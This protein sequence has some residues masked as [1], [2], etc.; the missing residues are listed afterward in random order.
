MDKKYTQLKQGWGLLAV[1]LGLLFS[2][3]TVQAQSGPYGNEWIVPSQQYYKIPVTRDGIHRLDYQYLTQAGLGNV[4]PSR[5]QLWR[6]GREVAVYQGGARTVFDASTYLE[7]Y[8]QRNDGQLDRDLYKSNNHQPHQLYSYYTDTAAY[9]LTY[10]GAGA[11]AARRMAE[12]L[13]AGG[14]PHAWRL[15][16]SLKVEVNSYADAP[17]GQSPNNV[18]FLPWVELGEGFYSQRLGGIADT[19]TDSLLRA[20]VPTGPGPAPRLEIRIVGSTDA[21]HNIELLVLNPTTNTYRSLARLVFNSYNFAGGRYALQRAEIGPNGLVAV[22]LSGSAG[23]GTS[24]S[25][26]YFRRAFMRVVAPQASRWI[27]P[28]RHVFFANDSLLGGP[29][30]FE[31]D[32]IPASVVGYD[33]HDP[34]NVQR[35]APAAAQTLGP[36]ARRFVF[37]SAGAARSRRLLLADAGRPFVPVRARLVRFRVINPATVNFAIITHRQMCGPGLDGTTPVA[38]AAL[39]YAKYRAS[40]AGGR[41]DTL[42]I[43]TAQLYD[44]FHY[45]EKSWLAMRHLGLWLAAAA[46]ANPNRYLLL[47]GKGIV[48]SEKGAYYRNNSEVTP[49]YGIGGGDFVLASSR[50]VSDNLIT[51]DYQHNDYVPK[52]HTGRLTTTTPQQVLNYLGKLRTHEALGAEPW[53]KNVLHLVGGKTVDEAIEFKGYLDEAKRRVERPYFG[54]KVTTEVRTSAL[55]VSVDISAQ[56]NAGLALIDF[57]GHASPTSYSLDFGRPSSALNYTN[58]GRYPYLFLNGCSAN[59]SFTRDFTIVED[60]LFTS[61]RGALGSLAESG[62]SYSGPLGVAHDTLYKLLFNDPNWYGKPITAVH[63]ELVRRLQRTS[64]FDNDTGV[65][66]LLTCG[67]QGDPTLALFAP[68]RPD[69]IASNATLSIAP[70][71]ASPVV[72]ASSDFVLNVGVANPGKITYEPVEIQ[73]TRVFPA[74]SGRPNLVYPLITRRQAWRPDTTYALTLPNTVGVGGT[75]TFLVALD[76]NNRV[77]E[78]S[79]TNNTATIDFSFLQGGLSVVSPTEF[80]ISPATQPRL[81][82]QSN[83]PLGGQRAYDFEVDTVTTF[84][85]G[86]VQ[87]TTV[88]AGVVAEWTP[89]LLATIG[90]RDSLVWYWRARFKTPAPGEDGSWATSSFRV[91][92]GSA[93]GWS[94]SHYAQFKRDTRTGV[95][96]SA[97]AGRWAFT[98]ARVPLVLRTRGGGVPRSAPSFQALL[99]AGIYLQSAAGQPSVFGCGV[100]SPNL[101]VAVYSPTSLRPVAM[102]ATFQR[103][104]QAPD[105]FYFFSKSDPVNQNSADTLDNLNYSAT[106]QQQ[107]NDFLTAVPVGSYV[108][109]VSTNRLRYTLLPVALKAR[110]QALLG[111]QLIARLADGEPLALVGQKLTATTGRLVREAGPDRSLPLPAYGQTVELRDSLRRPG[112][113]GRI[114]STRIGPAKEWTNLYSTIRNLAPSGRHTLSVVAI[115]TLGRETV[116]L[117]N[118][119]AASQPLAAAI[120]A[121]RYPY[122]RLE[123]ALADTVTRV[124]PQLQQ[125]LVTSRGLPEGVVRRDLVAATEYAPTTLAQQATG[126][127]YLSFPVKFANVS[128]ETFASPLKTRIR[129]RDISQASRPVVVD[130]LI[131]SLAPLPGAIQVIPVR[132]GVKGKFGTFV[133]EVVVNPRLQPEQNYANNELTLE[134]FTVLDNNVP[135]VL[136]VAFDGRHILNGELVSAR[137]VINIQ[138]NDEDKLRPITDRTVFTVTLL[139]PGRTSP[140]LVDLA[141]ANEVQFSVNTT[142]GSVAKLTYEPGKSTPLPDGMYTLEVQG[143]DPSNASAGSQNFQVKFEV[144]NSSQISNVYPYPNPVINKTRFVFTLTGQELPRNMKIQILSLTGRVVREI[145]MS[146]LGPLHIGNNITEFAWDGTD[147]YGDRLANGTYLY[148]VSLDDP[149]SNFGHR[150]TSGDKAFKNDWGKLV[151][152]R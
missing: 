139:R 94:Q 114:V 108:A 2:L 6:R 30:T 54:G 37:P 117:P 83:D 21:P 125:W 133:T 47:L 29:A 65:E 149:N 68:P 121:T 58:V 26:D 145:F 42:L 69:F 84:T 64:Y 57:F 61:Q 51:T 132:F 85:S 27:G 134:A 106:R 141:N 104:G 55:P 8:G 119:T 136:D 82:V 9:F 138:L 45:G 72:A 15:A 59:A 93:S 128:N 23:G 3:P 70:T 7:F 36:L 142:N 112:T 96:V 103:C 116:V 38:N 63:D 19:Q 150:A 89:T 44:Q 32:S 109:V 120:S 88:T 48:P 115:D 4:D 79:E 75:S 71:G 135:P 111:S 35:I 151:L 87:R 126:V 110:L 107:L 122:I 73:V 50:A 67:W 66:Q 113:N 60:W 24:S 62:Y 95:D 102:P 43:T 22:R 56:L 76:P 13:V 33:V 31:V 49:A 20:V 140:V 5:L 137:P 90:Q 146:E 40:T 92:P 1:L 99:G 41:Y 39:E 148:R 118:I 129:L 130:T 74:G 101:L 131:T 46:P 91:I 124:P 17:L 14:V 53:R 97:P 105:Y 12:P 80:A 144:V 77:A 28:R 100:Q 86:A 18:N 34:W 123:L 16:N 10:P 98:E 127:G 25:A 152:M 78:L 11:P 143:R 52:L 147:T 81:A